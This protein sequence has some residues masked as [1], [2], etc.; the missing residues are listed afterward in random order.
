MRNIEE[1][2]EEISQLETHNTK[3]SRDQISRPVLVFLCSSNEISDGV[4]TSLYR[5]SHKTAVS[6]GQA[7]SR[8]NADE[9]DW[10]VLINRHRL[11]PEY[12]H[13]MHED[14]GQTL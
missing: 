2:E 1:E 7:S 5:H 8:N 4:I 3:S 9:G 14:R 11:T 10:K 13:R 12:D 6:V